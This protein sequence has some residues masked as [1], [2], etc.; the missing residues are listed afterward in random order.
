M[1]RRNH[2]FGRVAALRNAIDTADRL[3]P[4]LA[5]RS[6]TVNERASAIERV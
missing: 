2:A 3:I 5:A 4:S 6:L 1:A